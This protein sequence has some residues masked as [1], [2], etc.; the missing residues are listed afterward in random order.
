MYSFTNSRK[1]LL[2]L[3]GLT[4]IDWSHFSK[5]HSFSVFH[6]SPTWSP[7]LQELHINGWNVWYPDG[8]PGTLRR[9]RINTLSYDDRN[10]APPFA[11]P[12]LTHLVVRRLICHDPPFLK[13]LPDELPHLEALVAEEVSH[14]CDTLQYSNFVTKC[15]RLTYLDMGP[16]CIHSTRTNDVVPGPRVPWP[17]HRAP[18]KIVCRSVSQHS[19]THSKLR[20]CSTISG[21]NVK[22]LRSV[23]ERATG[24]EEFMR[25][26]ICKFK[27]WDY[28]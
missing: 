16:I 9:L 26:W 8:L 6:N 20:P 13:K 24:R 22:I 7:V 14:Y 2:S 15:H 28:D 4:S 18:L 19:S 11:L 5:R 1:R 25:P 17:E 21:D 23:E 10:G 3:P 27:I 12:L